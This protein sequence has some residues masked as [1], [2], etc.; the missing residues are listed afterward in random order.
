MV[1]HAKQRDCKAKIKFGNFRYPK[2]IH[3]TGQGWSCV[4]QEHALL[5][6]DQ[7]FLDEE[8]KESDIHQTKESCRD[9]IQGTDDNSGEF[10]VFNDAYHV[11]VDANRDFQIACTF[12]FQR[13]KNVSQEYCTKMIAMVHDGM[14]ERVLETYKDGVN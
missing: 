9:A 7:V 5:K 1:I 10:V 4:G 6:M 11:L 14:T 2:K 8:T 3:E 13:R 12:S